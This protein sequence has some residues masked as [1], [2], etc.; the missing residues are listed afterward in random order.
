M[1]RSLTHTTTDRHTAARGGRPAR[2]EAELAARLP[3]ATYALTI[4]CPEIAEHVLAYI[5]VALESTSRSGRRDVLSLTSPT[6]VVVY[7]EVTQSVVGAGESSVSL[8][9]T[10]PIPGLRGL[11]GRIRSRISSDRATLMLLGN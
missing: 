7:A 5:D 10:Y 9:T 8:T 4:H 11:G 6:G 2:S 3:R 1:S